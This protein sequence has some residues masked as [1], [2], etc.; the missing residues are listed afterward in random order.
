MPARRTARGGGAESGGSPPDRNRPLLI[1]GEQYAVAV[2]R[3]GGGGDKYDPY[4]PDQARERLAPQ[5][6]VLRAEVQQLDT[7][8]RGPNVVFEAKLLA[9]YLA[10]SHFPA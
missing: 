9:N 2:E 4:T 7:A 8:F 10:G 6:A 5:V 3:A 1:G